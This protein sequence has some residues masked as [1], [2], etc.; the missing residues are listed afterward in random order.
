MKICTKC[1]C[2]KPLEDYPKQ[3]ERTDGRGSQ[4]KACNRER[5]N[6]GR[7]DKGWKNTTQSDL[8]LTAQEKA[9]Q[10]DRA[11][12][13]TT[14]RQKWHRYNSIKNRYGLDA[15]AYDAMVKDQA[16]CC[17]ICGCTLS[18]PHVDHCHKTG[19]VRGLLCT[20][21]NTGLGQFKDNPKFLE[22]AI[23]YLNNK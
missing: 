17:K 14:H 12:N 10:R 18:T 20:N 1:G 4:C 13:K 23:D 22:A 9:R 5:I 2:N 19:K 16:G 11:R 15:E 8:S 3:K 7:K 6:A 21:C